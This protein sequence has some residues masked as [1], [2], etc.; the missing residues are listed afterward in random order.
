MRYVPLLIVILLVPLGL[1][2]SIPAPFWGG[3]LSGLA[4][5]MSLVGLYFRIKV[6]F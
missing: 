2:L 5:L 3:A 1:L 6:R 4:L